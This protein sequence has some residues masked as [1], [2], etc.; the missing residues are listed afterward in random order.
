[1]SVD[2]L[3]VM[4]AILFEAGEPVPE[5]ELRLLLPAGSDPAA[6][7]ERLSRDYGGRG[8]V[9]SRT[10]GG[11][12]IRTAPAASDLAAAEAEPAPR[13]SRAALETA[14]C[15]AAFEEAGNPLTRSEIERVRGVGLSPNILDALLLLGYVRTGPRRET[16]GRPLTWL[17]TPHFYDAFGLGS[18]SEIP[19][20]V[21][22]REA[23]LAAIRMSDALPEDGDSEHGPEGP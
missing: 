19:A 20:F 5:E 2:P 15:I 22:M 4:E 6:L 16:R 10:R 1:M 14:A 3:A 12:A 9:V 11:Y 18:L 23:G 17:A 21:E 7:A 13:L 8:L